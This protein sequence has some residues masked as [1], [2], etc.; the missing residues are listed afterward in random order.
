MD[1]LTYVPQDKKLVFQDDGPVDPKLKLDVDQLNTLI[2][3]IIANG[4]DVPPIATPQNFNTDL[5]KVVKRLYEG[6]VNAFKKEKYDDSVKQFSI[7]IEM[8]CRRHKFEAFQICL[9]ELSMFLM[10]R[11]DANL[12]TK[13]YVAAFNDVDMLI[14]MQMV[15]PDNFLRRGVANFFLGN[16]EDARADYQRG[17]ALSP[18]NQRLQAELE[19]CLDKILEENGDY[20]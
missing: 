19:I 13:D 5:S 15:T 10:S 12:K 17:L 2:A 9:Q 8:I 14:S 7:G 6:G 4:S 20:L 18:G 3:E 11:S 1:I 16:Y